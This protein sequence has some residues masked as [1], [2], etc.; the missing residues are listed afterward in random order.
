MLI[1]HMANGLSFESFGAIVDASKETLY[2]WAEKHSDFLDA[3][4]LGTQKCRIFYEQAGVDGMKA[5]I[6]FFNDRIWRLNMINRFRD[7]WIDHQRVETKNENTT[8]IKGD[9]TITL[10]L[11]ED[12]I[13]PPAPDQLSKEDN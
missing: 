4:R 1:E 8:T 9:M 3:K 2:S 5:K 12:N 7:E 6:P 10:N 11:N 13:Q